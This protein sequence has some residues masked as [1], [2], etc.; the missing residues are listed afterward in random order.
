MLGIVLGNGPSKSAYNRSGD[1]VIGCNFPGEFSVDATVVCDEEIVFILKNNPEAI[2]CPMI[3]STK[4]YSKMKEYK[5][6]DKYTILAVFK[7]RDWFNAAHYAANYLLTI[8]C[9]QIDIWGCDS[10]F[11]DTTESTTDIIISKEDKS[12]MRFIRNWRNV[13]T[14]IFANNPMT[15]FKVIKYQ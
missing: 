7:P 6:E 10:I 1:I 8:G 11:A 12:D 14:D 2:T 3:V 9:A 5:I 4:V 13:W 15:L